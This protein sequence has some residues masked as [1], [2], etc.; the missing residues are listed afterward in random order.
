MGW[1]K[2]Y[3][4]RSSLGRLHRSNLLNGIKPFLEEPVTNDT[5]ANTQDHA[6]LRV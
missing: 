4:M 1:K 2:S 5:T 6:D 3:T